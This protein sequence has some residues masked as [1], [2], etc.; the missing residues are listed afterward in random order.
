MATDPQTRK[1]ASSENTPLPL[2]RT[3]QLIE[4][5]VDDITNT[6]AISGVVSDSTYAHNLPS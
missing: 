4:A 1:N 2:W 6:A 5:N 3:P